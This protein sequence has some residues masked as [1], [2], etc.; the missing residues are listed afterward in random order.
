MTSTHEQEIEL[1]KRTRRGDK[2]ARDEFITANIALVVHI[3]KRYVGRGVELD[4]LIQEGTFGLMTAVERFN[5]HKG[6]RFYT[7]ATYWIQQT[8][9]RA[10]ENQSRL[11]RLPVHIIAQIA[12]VV[13][14]INTLAQELNRNPNME[15]V[16]ERTGFDV[17][18]IVS[19]LKASRSPVYIDDSCQ[20][21]QCRQY[22]QGN[23]A[24]SN[25][26]QPVRQ[27]SAVK[28]MPAMEKEKALVSVRRC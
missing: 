9:G 18:K 20:H 2:A 17:D 4:D 7:Y 13:R 1:A 15:E 11:I 23:Q 24:V 10:I 19:L 16:A 26:A 3:A 12:E 5:Y 28:A 27:C 25:T 8:I 22:G 21:G 14:A 6:I